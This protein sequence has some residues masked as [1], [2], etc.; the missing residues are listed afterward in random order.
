MT[1]SRVK[2]AAGVAVLLCVFV[3]ANTPGSQAQ[4]PEGN[5]G[6]GIPAVFL[7]KYLAY[8]H[9]QLASVNPDLM[10]IKLG[11]VK[12]LSK[13]FVNMVGEMAVDLDSGAFQVSLNGLTPL[14]AYSLWL[15]DRQESDLIPPAPDTVFRLAT[16]VAATP[17][18]LLTG[19]LGLIL[20]FDFTIDR[21]VVVPGLVWGGEA[22]A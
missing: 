2:L 11:Y 18:T 6:V 1:S 15:V 7:P 3:S 4:E 16:L 21:V 19:Q 8:R 12:G 20:P 14:Q 13:S 10:R 17:S 22:L 9:A 5:Y